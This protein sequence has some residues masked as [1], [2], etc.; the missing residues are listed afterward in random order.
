VRV[1]ALHL[2]R[3]HQ[4]PGG[5]PR[6]R[7]RHRGRRDARRARLGTT[8]FRFRD[9]LITPEQ[10]RTLAAEL[11]ELPF[12]P[13]WSARARFE[14]GFSRELLRAA[15]A[16]GLEEIWL[17]LESAAPRVRNLM[18]KGVAQGVVERILVDCAEAGIRVRALC[19]LGYPGETAAEARATLDFLEQHMFRVTTLSLTPFQL[20]RNTPLGREPGRHGITLLPDALPRH[21]RL[22]HMIDGAWSGVQ[23]GEVAGLLR[24]ASDGVAGWMYERTRGPSLTHAWMR[25]TRAA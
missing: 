9:D 23:P 7:H 3:D 21:Q 17:G 20:M 25:A 15:A 22:R 24:E 18:V 11:R 14:N 1:G 2:L 6:A 13:H 19:I 12:R 4:P 16:A 5:V 10:L 8:Y